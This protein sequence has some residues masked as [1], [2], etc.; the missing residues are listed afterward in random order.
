MDKKR[1]SCLGIL[2]INIEMVRERQFARVNCESVCVCVC[3]TRVVFRGVIKRP[4]ITLFLRVAIEMISWGSVAF[5]ILN[6]RVGSRGHTG[7][8]PPDR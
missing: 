8:V 3:G 1:E 5:D 4:T 6:G 7:G 2:T